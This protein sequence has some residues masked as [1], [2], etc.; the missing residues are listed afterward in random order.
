MYLYITYQI[1]IYQY[2]T[3]CGIAEWA[4][5]YYLTLEMV[6]INISKHVLKSST[7]INTWLLIDI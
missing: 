2:I 7:F 4:F 5:A 1:C 3:T 6:L